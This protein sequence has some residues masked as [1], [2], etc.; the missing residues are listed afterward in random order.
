MA[1]I[2]SIEN[3]KPISFTFLVMKIFEKCIKNEL[4][5]VT[6]KFFQGNMHVNLTFPR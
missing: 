1:S 4:F 3:C 5:L 2:A 6:E